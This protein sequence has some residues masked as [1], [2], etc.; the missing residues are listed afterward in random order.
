[1]APVVLVGG[2]GASGD[3]RGRE[4]EEGEG[5]QRVREK[6]EGTQ[7][8]VVALLGGPGKQEV[9]RACPRTATTRPP[10]YWQ[11]VEDGGGDCWAGP[12]VLGR[13]WAAR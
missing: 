6:R 10:A 11:E 1:M 2:L 13:N 12:T 7:G 3:E 9:A 5:M 8:V 4:T